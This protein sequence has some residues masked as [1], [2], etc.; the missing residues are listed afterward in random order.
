[1]K[2]DEMHL[3][4]DESG[5]FHQNDGIRIIG[6]VLLFGNYGKTEKD[7]LQFFFDFCLNQFQGNFP[8][9]LHLSENNWE[10]DKKN[11]F[12]QSLHNQMK[13]NN[14][15][16]N[17]TFGVSITYEKDIS[18]N[19]NKQD[20]RYRHMLL[21]LIQ[22][23]LFV[24]QDVAIRS[25]PGAK[26]YITIASRQFVFNA[27]EYTQETL[28]QLGWQNWHEDN[29]NPNRRFVQSVNDHI[30]RSLIN[31]NNGVEQIWPHNQNIME[32]NLPSLDYI[33]GI[34]SKAL[35][36]AD[37]QLSA[38]RRGITLLPL[39]CDIKYSKLLQFLH[40]M[41]ACLC[42]NNLKDY[43]DNNNQFYKYFS[44]SNQHNKNEI[45]SLIQG[46]EDKAIKLANAGPNHSI[47][48]D[49][50]FESSVLVDQPGNS[51]EGFRRIEF[52][53]KLLG[54][55]INN[56]SKDIALI[57]QTQLSFY[58][59]KADLT[60]A[61]IIWDKFLNIENC[62]PA[63]GS[64]GI[65]F[66]IEIRNRRAVSLSDRF[67]YTEA[68]KVLNEIV[69]IKEDLRSDHAKAYGCKL[70]DIPDAELG[71]CY[72]TLG[73][74]YAF[75]GIKED[76]AISFEIAKSLFSDS[77]DIERQWVYLGHLACDI[78]RAN[79]RAN[80]M[81]LW[82][83]VSGNLA[84]INDNSLIIRDGNQFILEL[85]LKGKFVF[86]TNDQIINL[87]NLLIDNNPFRNLTKNPHPYGFIIQIAGLI[88]ARAW[89]ETKVERYYTKA[90]GFFSSATEIL[91]QGELLLKLLSNVCT[92]RKLL[93]EF[94]R[95]HVNNDNQINTVIDEFIANAKAIGE[96]AW[97]E[98][99]SGSANGYF[100]TQVPGQN[101][102][103]IE[104]AKKI[105][106]LIRFNYW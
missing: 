68:V 39:I 67:Y 70:E 32:I 46:L 58:N 27:H 83:E 66:K 25:K 90:I 31:S 3:F 44:E 99:A 21:F 8:S 98:D 5:N 53:E 50:I 80:G 18:D 40:K 36:L 34:S 72:G 48:S 97:S 37:L 106:D 11:D 16:F 7:A 77:K 59:H 38:I 17:R 91:T 93:L 6:G 64:D 4:I 13:E 88:C 43:L 15:L 61:N 63:L 103:T 101:H 69:S 54:P 30:I 85:Q 94:Q 56:F 74:L 76:A 95:N 28:K 41:D 42:K 73:Q 51:N 60:N 33:D 26:I 57:L 12:L 100:G 35:Y 20:N 96:H 22:H 23:L 81:K 89:E 29:A 79:G 75:Q 2:Y 92:L 14:D 105:M 55:R 24:S 49:Y 78:G 71:A 102:N 84:G 10:N 19:D 45:K 9:D 65:K 82:S 87:A 86:G 104:R 62:L 1:M 47:V 52:A